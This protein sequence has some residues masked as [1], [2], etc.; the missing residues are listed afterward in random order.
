MHFNSPI[1][2]GTKT[3]R[4]Y[5]TF[6]SKCLSA[7]SV[8]WDRK[9]KR[10]I[11][12]LWENYILRKEILSDMVIITRFN[13]YFLEIE[14]SSKCDHSINDTKPV[15]GSGNNGQVFAL[16]SSC[17]HST[18]KATPEEASCFAIDKQAQG[19]G[20]W[21]IYKCWKTDRRTACHQLHQTLRR[22]DEV[23]AWRQYLWLTCLAPGFL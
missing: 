23:T 2:E 16:L 11:L 13:N 15:K 22:Q 6:L 18:P 17:F 14:I 3:W 19:T 8:Q 10:Q 12:S 21:G 20:P 4:R 1:L 5:I 7:Y 9:V